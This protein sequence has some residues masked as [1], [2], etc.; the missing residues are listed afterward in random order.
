MSETGSRGSEGTDESDGAGDGN[1]TDGGGDGNGSATTGTAGGGALTLA[2]EEGRATLDAQLSALDDVD[3]KAL[4][5]FRLNVA[6]VGVLLSALSFAAGSGVLTVEGLLTPVVGG[7]TFL[8]GLSAVAAGLTYV[9]VGHRVGVAPAGLRTAVDADEQAFRRRLVEGYA[10]WIRA[11]EQAT[12]RKAL[13]V[14]L[15]IAGTVAGVLA[16]VVGV[17]GAFVGTVLVPGVVAVIVVV[18]LVVAFDIPRQIRRI[19]SP[20]DATGGSSG[21]GAGLGTV[22]PQRTDD[23]FEGQRAGAGRDPEE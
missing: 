16:L 21:A 23:A 19:R 20:Q 12:D 2:R 11:N 7:A 18:A 17:V 13:L 8:F 1:G 6:L 22:A 5:V 14:S 3:A 9:A 10:D 15:A 4:S